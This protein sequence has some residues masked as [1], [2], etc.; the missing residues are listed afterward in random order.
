MSIKLFKNVV[1]ETL[2][3]DLPHFRKLIANLESMTSLRLV[4]QYIA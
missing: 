1:A 3:P 4:D 2:Q